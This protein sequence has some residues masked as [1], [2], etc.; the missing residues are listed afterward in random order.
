MYIF[1]FPGL[2]GGLSMLFYRDSNVSLYL[3]W[4]SVEVTFREK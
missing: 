4:K 2:V 3:F 1:V